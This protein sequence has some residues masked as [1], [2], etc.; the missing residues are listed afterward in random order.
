MGDVR[1]QHFWP[2]TQTA[3]QKIITGR[4]LLILAPVLGASDW[5]CLVWM[6]GVWVADRH[7]LGYGPMGQGKKSPDGFEKTGWEIG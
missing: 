3:R 4:P 1:N 2:S 6:R 5:N 7:S